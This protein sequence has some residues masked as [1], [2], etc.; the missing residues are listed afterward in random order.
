MLSRGEQMTS[1]Q[2]WWPS[3][4]QGKVLLREW[5]WFLTL[6]KTISR[7][8]PFGT[9]VPRNISECGNVEQREKRVCPI[10]TNPDCAWPD[11]WWHQISDPKR[12]RK[13]CFKGELLAQG[14]TRYLG[15]FA[16]WA[17]ALKRKTELFIRWNKGGRG[18]VFH[19]HFHTSEVIS[20]ALT[21]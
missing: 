17:K 4:Q 10:A 6:C 11:L 15:S 1:A 7:E 19:T 14:S 5:R 2:C 16:G 21:K 3:L 8:S 9:Q 13:L 20:P 12:F 18:N